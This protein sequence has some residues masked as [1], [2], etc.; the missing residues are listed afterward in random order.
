MPTD[1]MVLGGVVFDNWS[2]PPKV[3]FGGKQALKVHK[4]PGGSRVFDLLG[5]DDHDIKF[6]GMIYNPDAAGIAESIDAMRVSGQ[7]VGLSFAGR[8]YNV[9]V[10][11]AELTVRRYPQWYEYSIS[12]CVVLDPMAGGGF[13]VPSTFADLVGADMA[14]ALA[15]SGL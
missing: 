7:P 1:Q 2:T 3:P 5:P 10:E 15:A 13:S 14:N 8:F 6:S 11:E 9:I 4:L 12:C